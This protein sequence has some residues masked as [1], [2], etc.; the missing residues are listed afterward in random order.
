MKFNGG[1]IL[2]ICT[3]ILISTFLVIY[4][5]QATGYYAYANYEKTNLTEEG[6][7]HFEQ[8]VADGKKIDVNNYLNNKVDYST[9]LSSAG[10]K[11]S[12]TIGK[13]IKDGITYVFKKINK[14]I[15]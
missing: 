5:S 10:L 1:Y 3:L 8:D 11:I 9:K 6:I 15:E 13:Y 4:L 7:K 14:L 2:K 12:N